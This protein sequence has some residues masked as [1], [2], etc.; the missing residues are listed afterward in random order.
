M[1]EARRTRRGF[2]LTRRFPSILEDEFPVAKALL[3]EEVDLSVP[4]TDTGQPDVGE[5]DPKV[6]SELTSKF[7]LLNTPPR[8]A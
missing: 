7:V 3:P 1:Y 8:Y 2:H 4:E 5:L 6:A